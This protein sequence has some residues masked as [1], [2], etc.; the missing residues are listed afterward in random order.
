MSNDR[1]DSLDA[2]IAQSRRPQQGNAPAGLND[3]RNYFVFD[4]LLSAGA[5]ADPATVFTTNRDGRVTLGD[6]GTVLGIVVGALQP[7]TTE[8]V[9]SELANMRAADDNVGR[10]GSSYIPDWTAVSAT[11]TL[12]PEVERPRLVRRNGTRVRPEWVI[13]P[14]ARSPYYPNSYPYSIV[15]QIFVWSD[16]AS[17]N[18]S[19]WGTAWL[20]RYPH[21]LDRQS[22]GSVGFIKL[23]SAVRACLLRRCFDPRRVGGLVG[24]QC[25]RIQQSRS[26]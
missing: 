14:D 6:S 25:P 1:P 10:D 19:W 22:R 2:F 13:D 4:R 20:L 11:P 23:E 9:A 8:Q 16:A 15:G 5:L 18:W 12:A 3:P 24:D 21:D 26:R 17:P 7:V